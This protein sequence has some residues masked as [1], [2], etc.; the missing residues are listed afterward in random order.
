MIGAYTP[1]Q[2]DGPGPGSIPRSSGFDGPLADATAAIGASANALR[3]AN[4]PPDSSITDIIIPAEP[5]E[6]SIDG[7]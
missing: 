1:A 3:A 7:G 2:M 5:V 6:E 4:V